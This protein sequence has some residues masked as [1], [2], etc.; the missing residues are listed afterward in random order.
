MANCVVSAHPLV[1]KE[2]W[3]TPV[4]TRFSDDAHKS[5]M[6]NFLDGISSIIN[7]NVTLNN[8]NQAPTIHRQAPVLLKYGYFK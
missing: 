4:L 8:E 7:S 2:Q 1:T 6:I 3:L 5:A